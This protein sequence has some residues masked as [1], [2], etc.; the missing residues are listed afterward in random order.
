MDQCQ[1]QEKFFPIVEP[2]NLMLVFTQ[3]SHPHLKLN[4]QEVGL[5]KLL[6]RQHIIQETILLP[7]FHFIH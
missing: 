2:F 6:K 4:L 5:N 7:Y 1:K 3:Q